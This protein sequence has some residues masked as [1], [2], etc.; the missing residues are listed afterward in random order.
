[1]LVRALRDTVRALTVNL[2]VISGDFT[3]RARQVEFKQ[4]RAFLDELPQPQ[5]A[6]PGNHDIALYNLYGRFVERLDTYKR[7][8][9]EDLEPCYRDA[10]IA[11]AGVNT[12]RS[13]TLKGGRIN[14]AQ[15]A[16]LRRRMNLVPAGVIKIVVVHHPVDL[17]HVSS[18]SLVGR[19]AQ[20]T[21]AM[22]ESGVDLV[23]SGHNHLTTFCDPSEA[24]RIGGHSAVLVQAGTAVSTRSRGEGNSFN[25]ITTQHDH[26]AIRS[27][28][29][30][31][32]E[33]VFREGLKAVF[34]R[35][36]EGW[37]RVPS[38]V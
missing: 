36:P 5:I 4:A 28:D 20:A 38:A 15:L 6:V 12:A 32:S 18:H 33:R 2:V 31:P 11:V 27:Y 29:W 16:R 17:P 22:L 8:V 23:L 3:Q 21:R 19:A 7:Y 14:P 24:R 10:E 13:L 26:I 37:R 35:Q 1:V 34:A 30:A 9:S 25:L